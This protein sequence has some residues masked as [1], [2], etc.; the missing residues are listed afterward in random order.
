MGLLSW[1]VA[2]VRDSISRIFFVWFITLLIGFTHLPHS[3]AGQ[4]EMAAAVFA[5]PIG[6]GAY[7]RFLLVATLGNAIGGVVF[8]ALVKYGHVARGSVAETAGPL[9]AIWTSMNGSKPLPPPK[10][11]EP[12]PPRKADNNRLSEQHRV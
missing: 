2:A 6:L 5:T 8:V 1:L 7:G 9:A 10:Q 3:I 11:A 12:K 4:I